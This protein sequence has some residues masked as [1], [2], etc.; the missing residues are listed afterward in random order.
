M[1]AQSQVCLTRVDARIKPGARIDLYAKFAEVK[2]VSIEKKALRDLT[3]KDAEAE[4]GYSVND[5]K[6]VW[7]QSHTVWNPKLKV[8]LVTFQVD[9]LVKGGKVK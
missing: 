6:T 1:G 8:F 3:E 7:K 2:A 9:K 4:G 5:F